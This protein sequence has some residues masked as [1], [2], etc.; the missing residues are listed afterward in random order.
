MLAIT[1]TLRSPALACSIVLHAGL[2]AWV[3]YPSAT[4]VNPHQQVI[5]ISV[6]KISPPEL[7]Q[8]TPAFDTSVEPLKPVKP[9]TPLVQRKPPSQSKQMRERAEM[10]FKQ[11]SPAPPTSGPQ[12]PEATETLAAITE[13]VFNA[14]YLHNMPPVYPDE[15]RRKGVQGKVLLVVKVTPQGNAMDISI[16]HSSGYRLLDTAARD[17]VSHWRFVPARRDGQIV[18]SRVIVPVEFRLE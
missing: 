3:T 10:P 12:A 14:T 4:P 7:P 11:A 17:A 2:L 5:D 13:P 8:A 6:V 16:A 1:T 18:E 15:A 9:D